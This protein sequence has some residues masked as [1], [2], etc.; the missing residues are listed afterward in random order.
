MTD[1]TRNTI[2]EAEAFHHTY[3]SAFWNM[4]RLYTAVVTFHESELLFLQRY[5]SELGSP[6]HKLYADMR[7]FVA[8]GGSRDPKEHPSVAVRVH[9][10]KQITTACYFVYATTIFD[11]FI[12]DTSRFLFL[13]D[14]G[15][16]GDDCR[17]PISLINRPA[18]R[19]KFVN[20]EVSKK[21]RSLSTH[22]SFRQRLEMLRTKF[23]MKFDTTG[24]Q[25][26][27][28]RFSEVRNRFVHDSSLFGFVLDESNQNA[29][30]LKTDPA[31]V[32]DV[33]YDDVLE[34]M[35]TYMAVILAVYCS[36]HKDVLGHAS[37]P[38]HKWQTTSRKAK[39]TGN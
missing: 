5:G 10:Y 24:F 33:S 2:V 14:L 36:V 28:D 4:T 27:L 15:Q 38:K 16:L 30:I 32:T 12:S 1:F 26:S 9:W 21:V 23:K 39:P 34:A 13:R 31:D 19:S 7:A 11:G 35:D 25:P 8:A 17:V 18:E 6:Q 3:T 37:E 29:V 20:E 22:N